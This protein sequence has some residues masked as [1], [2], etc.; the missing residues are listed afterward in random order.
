MTNYPSDE[1][2]PPRVLAAEKRRAFRQMM[3]DS[4]LF[5]QNCYHNKGEHKILFTSAR[6]Y[7]RFGRCRHVGCECQHAT[8][9]SPDV[10]AVDEKVVSAIFQESDEGSL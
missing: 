9:D 10:R 8:E 6:G 3:E 1:G 4:S 2:V 7:V 5:C